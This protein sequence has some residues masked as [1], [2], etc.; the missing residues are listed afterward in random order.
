MTTFDYYFIERAKLNPQ[1]LLVT[2][3]FLVFETAGRKKSVNKFN[4]KSHDLTH[5]NSAIKLYVFWRSLH[6]VE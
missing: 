1:I 5:R 3:F 2:Y 4:E 6:I